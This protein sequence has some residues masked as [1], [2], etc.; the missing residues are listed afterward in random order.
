RRN[1]RPRCAT[2]RSPGLNAREFEHG[3][4]ADSSDLPLVLG[5]AGVAAGLL[6]VDAVAVG[7]GELADGD[8]VGLG[9]AFDAALA[10]GGE[11]VVPVGVRGDARF[12]GEHVDDVV[13]GDV[14]E[15]HHRVDVLARAR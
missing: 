8:L 11:V 12:G 9:S 6:G 14:R 10:G 4:G 5:E 3:D 15:V 1:G 13:V 7:S 2:R